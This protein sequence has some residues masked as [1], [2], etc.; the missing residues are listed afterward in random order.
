VDS[1]HP[2]ADVL[3]EQHG[4]QER[5]MK[6]I[7]ERRELDISW[8]TPLDLPPCPCDPEIVGVLERAATEEGVPFRRMHSGAGHDTQNMARIARVAMLFVPSKDGRSHTPAEFTATADAV[9]G[10]RVLA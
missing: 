9:T 2:S 10:V 1:R 8:T 3:A 5:L 6:E 7:A 4:R